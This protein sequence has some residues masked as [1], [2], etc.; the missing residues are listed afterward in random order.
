M[1][2]W[3]AMILPLGLNA[4]RFTVVAGDPYLADLPGAREVGDVHKETPPSTLTL[5]R[6]FPFGLKAQFALSGEL[7]WIVAA[8]KKR[9][10]DGAVL[11]AG[12]QALITGVKAAVVTFVLPLVVGWPSGWGLPGR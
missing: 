4:I 1:P 11:A 3:M 8:S 5:A 9:D 12:D 2:V 6:V 10:R 7:A